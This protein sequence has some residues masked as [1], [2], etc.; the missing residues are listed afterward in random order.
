MKITKEL[1]RSIVQE[2]YDDEFRDDEYEMDMEAE[3]AN[4]P[5]AVDNVIEEL[6]VKLENQFYGKFSDEEVDDFAV[7]AASALGSALEPLLKK[8]FSGRYKS[9]N[10]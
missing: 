10:H 1:I 3:V 5:G 9:E 6:M 4:D 2:S 7:E 8:L